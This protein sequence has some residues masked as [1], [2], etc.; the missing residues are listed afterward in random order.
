MP[1]GDTIFKVA[2]ALRPGLTGKK[3]DRV[4][5]HRRRTPS[6]ERT[7]TAV[8]TIGKHLLIDLEGGETVRSHLGMTGS[9][10]RYPLA[11]PWQRPSRQA[12]LLLDTGEQLFVCFNAEEIECL[13]R[14]R[15][16]SHRILS[17]LGPDLL[18]PG[19]ELDRETVAEIARRARFYLRSGS[20][21]IDLLLDQRVACGLGNV[22]K[23]EVLFLERVLPTTPVSGLDQE[24][25]GSLYAT[26]QRLLLRNLGDGFRNTRLEAADPGSRTDR[27]WVY[28]RGG[29]PC[30][31]CS[32][33]I[34]SARL[35]RGHR[36]TFWCSDCQR[37]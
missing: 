23:S 3:L 4:E 15:A 12:S 29:G 32:S 36:N 16:K 19:V 25:L 21:V 27:L 14:D 34:R 30:H 31:R 28:G 10:H 35:G 22:Y 17:R 33:T 5:I 37:A 1:E 2:A 13:D 24:R 11:A 9:W 7:V 18:D 26:G 20:P 8:R 6:L